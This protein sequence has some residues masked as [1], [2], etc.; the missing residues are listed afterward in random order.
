MGLAEDYRAYVKRE[1]NRL[2]R[3][4][5]FAD[6]D[7]RRE[8][9]LV[10]FEALSTH[11][12]EAILRWQANACS[13]PVFRVLALDFMLAR[14]VESPAPVE[15][16]ETTLDRDTI[17][18]GDLRV[19]GN[20]IHGA[21]LTVLGDLTIEGAYL[22]EGDYPCCQVGGTFAARDYFALEAETIVL[23]TLRVARTLAVFYPETVTIAAAVEA[24]N[25]CS[26]NAWIVGA[27]KAEHIAE[28]AAAMK[29]LLGTDDP[30]V[31]R[32][33]VA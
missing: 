30:D 21:A 6:S 2:K 19:T 33:M 10:M 25:V 13:D 17:V 23:G 32:A 26:E 27:L 1:K 9:F 20:L 14:R 5:Y 18:E 28:D 31:V 24:T 8:A 7:Q 11:G 16:P 15:W 29:A 12:L 4:P 3:L 22:T